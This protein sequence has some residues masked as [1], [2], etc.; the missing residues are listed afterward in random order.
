ME[1]PLRIDF[2]PLLGLQ[3]TK[4]NDLGFFSGASKSC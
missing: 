1:N 2:L 3:K 4:Q